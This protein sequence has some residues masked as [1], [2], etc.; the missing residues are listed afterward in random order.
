MYRAILIDASK[1]ELRYVDVHNS[2]DLCKHIGCELF[3]TAI[4]FKNDY[5]IFVDDEG[6]LKDPVTFFMLKHPGTM[7]FA[8]NGIVLKTVDDKEVDCDLDI[9]EL[10]NNIKFMKVDDPRH[11]PSIEPPTITTW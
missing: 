7:W 4:S 11:G 8:G 10:E 6:Y 3:T 5:V 2:E 1:A 9:K